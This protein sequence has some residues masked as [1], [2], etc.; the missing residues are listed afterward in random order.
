[1]HKNILIS[2][3]LGPLKKAIGFIQQNLLFSVIRYAL[4]KL[5][6]TSNYMFVCHIVTL[7]HFWELIIAPTHTLT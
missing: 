1:M 4:L 5:I 3:L 7:L 2:L 6:K